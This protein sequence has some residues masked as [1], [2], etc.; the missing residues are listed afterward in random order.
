M[1][2][3]TEKITTITTDGSELRTEEMEDSAG[4][5]YFPDDL[6]MDF[7]FFCNNQPNGELL[8]TPILEIPSKGAKRRSNERIE[9]SNKQ[10]MT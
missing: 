7:E 9:R 2:R 3:R 10:S 4:I 5:M 8:S 1:W 6:Q